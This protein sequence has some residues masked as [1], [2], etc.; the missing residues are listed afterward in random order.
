MLKREYYKVLRLYSLREHHFYQSKLRDF[1]EQA[2][3]AINFTIKVG[4][5]DVKK[6]R[7]FLSSTVVTVVTTIVLYDGGVLTVRCSLHTY[8]YF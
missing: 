3:V 1:I 4:F 7:I 8:K 5:R 6:V 2:R